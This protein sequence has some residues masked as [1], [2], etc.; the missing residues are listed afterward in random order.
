M[1]LNTRLVVSNSFATLSCSILICLM[2]TGIAIAEDSTS[3]DAKQV[4]AQL[5][6]LNAEIENYKQLLKNTRDQR[7]QLETE[8]MG[9]EKA[10]DK[11]IRRIKQIEQQLNKGQ[12]K[13]RQLRSEKKEL[14]RAIGEQ[15]KYLKEQIRAAYAMGKQGHLKVLLNQEDPAE[16]SRMLTYYDYFNRARTDQVAQYTDLLESLARIESNIVQQTNQLENAKHQLS[17]QHDQLSL[18]KRKR[19]LALVRLK[20]TLQDKE[21]KLTKLDADRKGL[22]SL[23][24]RLN[25]SLELFPAIDELN[26]FEDQK[27]KM[28]LPVKGKITSR[29]GSSRSEGKQRWHGIFVA[30]HEGE[31]VH[32]VHAGRRDNRSPGK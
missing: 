2:L 6:A 21:A 10:I 16:I 28:L 7:S 13:V 8:L 18:S 9:N 30:T 14:K 5:D 4:K 26:S 25:R 22:E 32:A 24:E 1:T 20:A 17:Q 23:L 15:Q 12:K 11:L 27:G 3:T 29:F 31:P 19:L